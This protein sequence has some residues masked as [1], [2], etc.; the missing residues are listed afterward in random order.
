[1]FYFPYNAPHYKS[2]SPFD[3]IITIKTNIYANYHLKKRIDKDPFNF[4]YDPE[5][6]IKRFFHKK[7]LVFLEFENVYLLK[8]N[9]K[10]T[11]N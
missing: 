10:I 7:T 4:V 2:K 1:M 11:L 5:K 9:K 3:T 6:E 8:K